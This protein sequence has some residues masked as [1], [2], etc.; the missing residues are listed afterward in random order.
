MYTTIFQNFIR[1]FNSRN[2]RAM[3]MIF[4]VNS[5]IFASWIAHIPYVKQKLALSDGELGMALFGMPIG[6]LCMN[7]FTGT[8][9]HRFGAKRTTLWSAFFYILCVVLPVNAWNFVS[10]AGALFLCGLGASAM[11]VAMNTCA[12][13]VE[14]QDERRILS[15][16]HGM[17]SL[18][19]VLGSGLAS[20]LIWGGI[21]PSVHMLVVGTVL[22]ALTMTWL[23]QDFEHI[24]EYQ[25]S[26]DK[27]AGL[28][29]PSLA[30]WLMIFIG[31][32][33]SMGEGLAF[34]WSG[35]YLRQYAGAPY[36]VASLGFAL[37]A[38]AMAA[39]RFSGD[40]IVPLL[41]EKKILRFGAVFITLGIATCILLPAVTTCLL[42]FFM[43]G[44]G[45]SL[46]NPMLYAMSMR[47]P[48]I[49][50]AAGL[51]TFASLS[52]LGFLAGPPLIGFIADTWN[53]AYGLAFVGLMS[54]IS[55]FV[56]KY[57]TV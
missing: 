15:S 56:V 14:R 54:L 49:M 36:E 38:V 35:V 50:P 28:V 52:M 1:F 34:D 39:G 47:I 31:V 57:I 51:A 53:L 22:M 27:P 8:I 44:M 30:L 4:A 23:R 24:R 10:L 48:G 9:I 26:G 18:G 5:M 7:P 40:A 33:V 25:E 12:V 46:G 20:V 41:G 37:F 16:C 43:L 32:S 29:R 6:L 3:G 13:Y 45:C 55:F 2:S 42:G 19:G 21:S 11:N 17:W